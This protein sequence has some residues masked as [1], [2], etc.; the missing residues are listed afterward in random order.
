MTQP[1]SID[2]AKVTAFGDAN[3][4]LAAEV[5]AACEPDPSLV[6]SVGVYGAAGAMF[7]VA[8][9]EY[10][11]KLQMSGE[12]LADRYHTHA[13]D[14]RV[15]AQAIVTADVTNAQRVPHR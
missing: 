10:L 14:I 5:M 9:C 7:S 12:Q 15:A 11:A 6:A 13:S 3:D 1:M 2:A 4:G 8:L